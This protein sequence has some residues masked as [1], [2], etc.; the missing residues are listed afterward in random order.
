LFAGMYAN[1]AIP[2]PQAATTK[3]AD[4][5]VM[6]P[7]TSIVYKDALTGLYTVGNNNIALLRWVRLGKTE[8]NQVEV[9]S[10]LAKNEQF[11]STANGRLFNGATVQIKK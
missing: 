9:L 4:G 6:V 8:G 2:I 1:V 3:A 10:G 7:L 11:I 5:Q